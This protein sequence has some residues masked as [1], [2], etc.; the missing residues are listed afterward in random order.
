MFNLDDEEKYS[1]NNFYVGELLLVEKLSSN[2]GKEALG[3][4]KKSGAKEISF[5]N[6]TDLKKRERYYK[7]L[8]I[9]MKVNDSY[10][11]LHDGNVYKDNVSGLWSLSSLLP[12]YSYHIKDKISI[13]KSLG[14][15]NDLFH[16]GESLECLYNDD[17]YDANDF[18]VGTLVLYNEFIPGNKEIDK[19]YFNMPFKYILSK[20]S[21]YICSSNKGGNIVDGVNGLGVYNHYRSVFLNI[22]G[23]MYSING[24]MKLDKYYFE[25]ESLGKD[26]I[27]ES[28][29][30]QLVPISDKLD[31]KADSISI[32]KVLRKLKEKVI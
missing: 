10:L 30:K 26:M 11:C 28:Y 3:R 22:N 29:C 19:R 24:F 8:T 12:K 18:Y 2:G 1:I 16:K 21:S 7:V 31:I 25:N 20:N 6:N 4:L 23:I 27:G 9:F 13:R 14:L 17:K 32:P 5:T 15:Y